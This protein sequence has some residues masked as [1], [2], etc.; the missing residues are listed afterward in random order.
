V[1]DD[2][3]NSIAALLAFL[4]CRCNAALRARQNNVDFRV[5][6]TVPP[7][8]KRLTRPDPGELG[9]LSENPF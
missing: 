4:F 9:N 1:A 5:F 6:D 2:R 7:V 3:F 8:A